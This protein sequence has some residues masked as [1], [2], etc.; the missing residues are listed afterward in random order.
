MVY[1][2]KMVIFH[3]YVSLPEGNPLD[4]TLT[5]HGV[6]YLQVFPAQL[7]LLWSVPD[8]A[9]ARRS[10]QCIMV[11]QCWW[12]VQISTWV[13][14]DIMGLYDGYCYYPGNP[15]T[16]TNMIF[17]YFFCMMFHDLFPWYMSWYVML[18]M[19][20]FR[21]ITHLGLSETPESSGLTHHVRLWT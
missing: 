12:V 16:V 17:H 1:L 13:H 21:G 20:H 14:H 5:I 18:I 15:N 3:I 7:H 10:P 11:C 6:G 19:G 2:L 4:P 9:P 8:L